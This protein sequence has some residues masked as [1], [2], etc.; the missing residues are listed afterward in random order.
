[1][2]N[3]RIIKGSAA[4]LFVCLFVVSCG[5]GSSSGSRTPLGTVQSIEIAPAA[6]MLRDVSSTVQLRVTGLTDTGRT[7][8]LT[9]STEGT[10]YATSSMAV[11]D[12]SPEGLVTRRGAG[13]AMLTVTNGLFQA[14]ALVYADTAS[15]LTEGDFDFQLGIGP[16]EQGKTVTVPLIL[17]AG[18]K[19]FGSYRAL[20]TFDPAHFEFVAA[21][22]G[23]DV[24][25]PLAVRSDTPGEVEVL[26]TY[27]PSLGQSLTGTIELSRLVLRAIGSQGDASIITGNALEVF[28]NDFPA[29]SI[30]PATP[31]PFVSGSRWLVID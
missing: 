9:A 13:T 10:T 12:V 17:D 31:R 28:N 14:T 20:V 5:G 6:V 25:A 4:L 27:A 1:M 24:Q 18:S 2:S 16:V 26:G 19:T 8:D 22:A 7:V 3:T 21:N 30:G 23:S 29:L 15:P 11:A